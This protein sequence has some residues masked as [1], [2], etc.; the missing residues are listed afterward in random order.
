MDV[1]NFRQQVDDGDE[2]RLSFP[3]SASDPVVRV[4]DKRAGTAKVEY[5]SGEKE[6]ETAFIS[7]ENFDEPA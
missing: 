5:L 2:W 6:G 3:E 7:P 4:M 1:E